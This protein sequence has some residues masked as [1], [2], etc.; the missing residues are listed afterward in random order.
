MVKNCIICRDNIF[1]KRK[2]SY[3]NQSRKNAKWITC[4]KECSK[5]YQRVSA[6]LRS[7][8]YIRKKNGKDIT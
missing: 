3:P 2:P 1:E 8:H 7:K 4:S 5:I 6:Y